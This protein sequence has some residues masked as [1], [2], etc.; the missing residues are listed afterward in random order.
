MWAFLSRRFRRW[1]LLVVAV[2]LLGRALVRVG[3]VLEERRGET[4]VTRGLRGIGRR[5]GRRG[6]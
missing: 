6:R 5:V 3:E 1:L 2:P 4:L